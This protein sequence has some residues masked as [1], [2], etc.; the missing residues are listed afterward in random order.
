MK[1]YANKPY[2]SNRPLFTRKIS[3]DAPETFNVCKQD[4]KNEPKKDEPA[5]TVIDRAYNQIK[6]N[7]WLSSGIPT[8]R[9]IK[10]VVSDP[11][12]YFYEL[13]RPY[14]GKPIEKKT[15]GTVQ[16]KNRKTKEKESIDIKKIS[17]EDDNSIYELKKG[18]ERLA[19]ADVDISLQDEDMYVN[20]ASTIVGRED[21]RGL[22]LTLMQA[23]I[24]DCINNGFIPSIT[25]T[26][27][28]VGSKN[29]DRSM[30]YRFYGAEYKIIDG[31]Y[32]SE[33]VC[34]ISKDK[35]IQMLENIQKSATRKFLFDETEQNF[36]RLK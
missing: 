30:L 3:T 33:P 20:Y 23:M 27:M 14:F 35:V 22:F 10:A 17:Y 6:T 2:I 28:Q 31:E 12:A 18:K 8:K 13:S 11:K 36:Q 26:P 32:G 29:F 15:L 16:I 21:Y 25:A 4:N 34:E 5:L 24:E 1:I 19:F 9:T 7:L